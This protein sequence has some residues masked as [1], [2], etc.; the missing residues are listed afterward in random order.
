MTN[1]VSNPISLPPVDQP[2]KRSGI[3]AF[4]MVLVVFVAGLWLGWT[5]YRHGLPY[6]DEPD[7]M[8]IWTMGRAYFDPSWPM[9]QPHY[10]PGML[11]VSSIVQRAQIVAGNPFY[12]ES[13]TTAIMRI[14]SVI[15]FSITLL[16]TMWLAYRFVAQR[17]PLWGALAAIVAGCA[18][19]FLPVVLARAKLAVIDPWLWLW[20]ISS[21]AAGVEGWH[22]RSIRWIALS[23]I[24][25]MIA[26]LFK[27]QGASVL[28]ISGLA[29]LRFWPIDRKRTV[30]YLVIYGLVVAAFAY[31][32]VFIYGA[33][34]GDAYLP[35]TH[36]IRPTLAI[37]LRNIQF[38]LTETGSP[39]VFCLLPALA[40]LLPI[41]IPAARRRYYVEYPLWMF[42]VVLI[43]YDVILSFNGAPVFDRQY[44]ALN[45]L[46][47]IAAGIGVVIVF[48]AVQHMAGQRWPTQAVRLKRLAFIVVAFLLG[49]GLFGPWHSA[50]QQSYAANQD[51]LLPDRRNALAQW[52]ST[53]ATA[54]PLIVTQVNAI[55]ALQT[56]YGYKGRPLETPFNQG[57]SILPDEAHITQQLID[58][59]HI[60]YLITQAHFQ[61]SQLTSPLT[62]LI[63]YDNDVDQSF[64]GDSWAAFYV[65]QLP[66]L[67]SPSQV[68]TFNQEISLRGLSATATTICSGGTF[69]L[70]TLWSAPKPPMLN[71][72]FYVHLFSPATGEKN[73]EPS[74]APLGNQNRM[75]TSWTKTDELFIGDP[76][77]TT[78]P[79]DLP[80]GTY[81][82]WLGVFEPISGRRLVLADGKDHAQ[83]ET[84][85]VL[86]CPASLFF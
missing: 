66:A 86:T 38:Q 83:V 71:Y 26:A 33:L 9:F 8:T 24:L 59:G 25:A 49:I 69:Q 41:F 28:V 73:P 76:F 10:P 74:S 54:G 16:L 48:Q 29:C 19:I 17:T 12:D 75:T 80:P 11:F 55:A 84:L 3:V 46:Q 51:D 57:T 13:G 37:V 65:G 21:V 58:T 45:T 50:F 32:V 18:W 61:D 2:S 14:L 31:W 22:H 1:V 63:T 7:E 27:W 47:A 39:L 77:R 64:R 82:I 34:E 85:N 23:L 43:S 81:Q 40:L 67:F 44:L 15:C 20:M 60:K 4:V 68:V 79:K 42:P 70:Q 52:A 6:I 56:L 30:Y 72:S 62:R 53:T 35:G 5:G 78:L 36:T